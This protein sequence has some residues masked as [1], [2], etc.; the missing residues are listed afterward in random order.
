MSQQPVQP[1]PQD[2][3]QLYPKYV[4]FRSDTM[5]IVDNCFVLEPETDINAQSAIDLYADEI[6]EEQP[7]LCGDLRSWMKAVRDHI[8]EQVKKDSQ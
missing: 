7:G 8:T 4:V 5:E 6:E 2:T 1:P 3:D